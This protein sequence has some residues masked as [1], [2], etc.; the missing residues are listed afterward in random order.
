MLQTNIPLLTLPPIVFQKCTSG[1]YNSLLTLSPIAFQTCTSGLYIPLLTLSPIAFQTW[2]AD[3]SSHYW[4]YHPLTSRRVPAVYTS[5]YW[6][7]HPLR[8]RRVPAVAGATALTAP[9]WEPTGVTAAVWSFT[10]GI[11]FSLAATGVAVMRAAGPV[12]W[13]RAHSTCNRS[14]MKPVD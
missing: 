11:Q 2:P 8:S 12:P 13:G 6:H 10:S 14:R 4:H 7:Y 5:H 1:L 3:Y 9:T